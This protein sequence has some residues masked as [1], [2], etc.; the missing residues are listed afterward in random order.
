MCNP[1]RIVV[2]ASRD[3]AEAWSRQVTRSVALSSQVT[4]EA[5]LRQPLDD[6]LGAPVLAALEAL[7]DG[8]VDGWEETDQGYRHTVEGGYVLYDLEHGALEIVATLDDTVSGEAS[9]AADLSG[10]L[11]EQLQ[12]EQEGRYYDDGWGGRT[13]E[14]ARKEA[15]QAAQQAL[16]EAT[17]ERLQAAG[18]QAEEA[19]AAELQAQAEAEAR[20]HLQQ[21][22]DERRAA[23]AAQA[24]RHL[25]TVGLRCRQAFNGLLAGAYRDAI[26][27]YARAHGADG[28]SCHEDDGVVDIEF[29]VER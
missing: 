22:A 8:G 18:D 4:G 26:L 29:F 10:V 19:H 21:A 5:R 27:A 25:D 17:R 1:R 24:S 6:S 11:D 14:T 20:Q 23:L 13:E 28:L 15:E 16:D 7:L 12:T 2:S 3:I 9:A